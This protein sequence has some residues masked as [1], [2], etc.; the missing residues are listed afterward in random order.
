LERLWQVGIPS[1]VLERAPQLRQEGFAI[2]TNTN[3]WRALQE[4]GVD[5]DVRKDTLQM[6]GCV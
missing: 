5:E 6:Q 2:G 3:A 1:I 4:L